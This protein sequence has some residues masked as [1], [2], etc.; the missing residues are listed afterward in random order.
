MEP[1]GASH[2]VGPKV[3]ASSRPRFSKRPCVDIARHELLPI[4]E[5][6]ADCSQG[7]VG[8]LFDVREPQPM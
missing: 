7:R 5:E 1:T 2:K 6:R 4:Q 3:Y 8:H